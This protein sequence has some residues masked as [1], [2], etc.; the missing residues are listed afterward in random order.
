M[1]YATINRSSIDVVV[2]QKPEAEA[3]RNLLVMVI[4]DPRTSRGLSCTGTAM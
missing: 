1:I 3:L 4:I 2:E